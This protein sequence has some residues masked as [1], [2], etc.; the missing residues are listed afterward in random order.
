MYKRRSCGDHII[1]LDTDGLHI[2]ISYVGAVLRAMREGLPSGYTDY[3]PEGVLYLWDWDKW[4]EM[5]RYM[6][7]VQGDPK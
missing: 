7:I 1:T 2:S 5:P 4:R 6:K 3:R